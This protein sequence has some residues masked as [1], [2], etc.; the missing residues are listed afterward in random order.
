MEHF[1]KEM[2]FHGVMLDNLFYADFVWQKELNVLLSDH[3]ALG[4]VKPLIRTVFNHDEVEAAFRYLILVW[5]EKRIATKREAG[6]VL[7][8]ASAVTM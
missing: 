6:W 5:R 2:S 3:I 7:G 8:G 4:A 1:L